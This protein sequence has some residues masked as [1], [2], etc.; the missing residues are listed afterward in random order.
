R[1]T[2]NHFL[3]G[4]WLAGALFLS[5]RVLISTLRHREAMSASRAVSEVK[6]LGALE[7]CKRVIGLKRE[8]RLFETGVVA[9]PAVWGVIKPA[10]LM[11][12]DFLNRYSLEEL[13]QIYLHELAHIQRQD[14]A[15]NWI[16]GLVQII[17]WFNPV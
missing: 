4:V 13:K 16:L 2:L 11:P 6:A 14:I 5:G 1:W 12:R 7:E 3:F 9:G 15:A 8:I 17:H 10:I